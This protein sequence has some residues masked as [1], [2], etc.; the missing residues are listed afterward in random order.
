MLIS[1]PPIVWNDEVRTYLT[2]AYRT[3][4]ASFRASFGP[5]RATLVMGMTEWEWAD[6][7]IL[8]EYNPMSLNGEKVWLGCV[9]KNL[10]IAC[11][12]VAGEG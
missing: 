9:P 8:A 12:D 2:E 3:V 6:A 5:K 11:F 10:R 7:A 1:A 4:R